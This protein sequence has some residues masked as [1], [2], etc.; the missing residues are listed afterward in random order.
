MRYCK[1]ILTKDLKHEYPFIF[2]KETN[3]I[4]DISKFNKLGF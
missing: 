2:N 1:N 3:E 4:V